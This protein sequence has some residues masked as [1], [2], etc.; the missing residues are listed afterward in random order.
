VALLLLVLIVAT[1]GPAPAAQAATSQLYC[2]MAVPVTFTPGLSM[3]PTAQTFSGSGPIA[4]ARQP[5]AALAGT[6]SITG[7][8]SPLDVC[9]T[10]AGSGTF[11]ASLGAPSL[12]VTG[13]FTFLRTGLALDGPITLTGNDVGFGNL[14]AILMPLGQNCAT[15]PIRSAA[16]A[17]TANAKGTIQ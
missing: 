2:S 13:R 3:T 17:G 12:N 14:R 9:A 10:G 11:S 5:A 16:L 1:F 4:C 6:I 7:T 8:T 15:R